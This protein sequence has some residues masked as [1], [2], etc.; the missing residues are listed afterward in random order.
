M[1]HMQLQS[2]ATP[3][4]SDAPDPLEAVP[5]VTYRVGPV[6]EHEVKAAYL[7]YL[8]VAETALSALDAEGAFV[9]MAEISQIVQVFS[10]PPP[11]A[12]CPAP[13]TLAPFALPHALRHPPAH[14]PLPHS[15]ASALVVV[16]GQRQTSSTSL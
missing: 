11:P 8:S 5:D 15:R 2:K 3:S 10:T 14:T 1:T 16:I 7:L 6:A 13:Q 9:I 4:D 12:P